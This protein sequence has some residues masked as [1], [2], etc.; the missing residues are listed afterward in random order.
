METVFFQGNPCHTCG[1]VPTIGET[2]P[3]YHLSGAD[4]SNIICS[5]FA[6]KRVVLNIF[7]SLDTEVCARSVRK[8]N[9]EAA[10]LDDVVVLCVSM[11][12]PFAMGRF[13]STEGIKDVI[14]ASAFRSPLFGQKYGVLLVD[15]P[16]AG[17][18]TRAVLILDEN[19][20]VIYRDVVQEITNDP[21]YAAAIKV[22]RK[23]A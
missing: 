4:L 9:E 22:L 14:P 21:D 8:F 23:E 20:R 1:T 18:L 12:L 17:L 10:R 16:L 19:R 7:P 2:A 15:G 11:D 5:D 6:S 3:C 13:C